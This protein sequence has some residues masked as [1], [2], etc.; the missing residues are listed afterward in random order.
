SAGIPGTKLVGIEYAVAIGAI[1]AK[2]EKQLQVING[3]SEE[4]IAAA[5]KMVAD[6]QVK[7]ELAKVPEKLYIEVEVKGETKTAKA[8]IANVHTNIIYIEENGTA[9]L[10]K[11]HEQQSA[12]SGYSDKEIKEI[13][14]V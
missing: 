6:K 13:L 8:I 3:L 9:V 12:D 2:P 4:Q 11:R 7:V 14:S 10:D 1:V 5:S